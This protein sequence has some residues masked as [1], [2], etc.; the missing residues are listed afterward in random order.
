[1]KKNITIIS[2][3]YLCSCTYINANTKSIDEISKSHINIKYI[4]GP[5]GE[6][7]NGK[8][9]KDPLFR[10]DAFDCLTYVETVVAEKISNSK[11]IK[12]IEKKLSKIRYKDGVVSFTNRNHFTSIDWLPNNNKIIKNITC[13]TFDKCSETNTKINKQKWL[14][15]NH[16]IKTKMP[17]KYSKVEYFQIKDLNKENIKNIPHE[18]I[19]LIV[20]PNWNL[21]KQIGTNLDIS[22]LG[23]A[24]KKDNEII[25]RHASQKYKKVTEENLF[26]YLKQ[27]EN[28]KTIK[29]FSVI[30][31]QNN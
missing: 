22:H 4:N 25:F 29:G 12:E 24:I 10:T 18:S 5:L 15:K 11:D 14:D 7:E 6:G 9:D 31:I 27:Y 2:L 3:I 23:F 28:S 19:I 1:M 8:V 20:R 16:N 30:K 17:E 13:E 21:K 26:E